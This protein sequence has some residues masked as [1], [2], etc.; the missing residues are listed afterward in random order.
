MWWCPS[1]LKIGLNGS[2]T[3][4]LCCMCSVGQTGESGHKQEHSMNFTLQG[5]KRVGHINSSPP[6]PPNIFVIFLNGLVRKGIGWF[7]I[8]FSFPSASSCQL[9][10]QFSSCPAL[11]QRQKLHV[12]TQS[13][14]HQP[15]CS[16]PTSSAY[17]NFSKAEAAMS[18]MTVL[19]F[20]TLPRPFYKHL[21]QLS[22]PG[23]IV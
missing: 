3:A 21:W 15:P 23:E 13:L 8:S 5:G 16:S 2:V 14:G 22:G 20:L 4:Q 6:L 7:T 17:R 12:P 10:L 1:R 9:P 11:E 19:S 18:L